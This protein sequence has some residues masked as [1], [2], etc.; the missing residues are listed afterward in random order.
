MWSR[1]SG[2]SL[3]R[4]VRPALVVGA[5]GLLAGCFQPLYAERTLK[6]GAPVHEAMRSIE[7][8]QI[9]APRGGPNARVAVALRDAVLFDLAGGAG[10]LSPTH[11]LRIN[12]TTSRS[13][14]IVDIATG[15]TIDEVTGID[16][17]YTLTEL[18]TGKVVVNGQAFSRVSSDVPGLEQRYALQRG[19]RDAEDRAAKVVADQITARLQSYLVAG[20]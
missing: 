18:A 15:Q 3:R 17:N 1:D 20:T 19:E 13:A 7:V 5:A 14:L 6:G 2:T 12:V 4:L 8:E 9:S 16:V 11:R 10:R